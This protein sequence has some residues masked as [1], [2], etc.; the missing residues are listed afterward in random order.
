MTQK[1]ILQLIEV[2]IALAQ[3]QLSPGDAAATLVGVVQRGL[4]AYQTHT[5]QPMDPSLIKAEAPL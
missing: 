5:G 4:S 3:S 1:L 2:L